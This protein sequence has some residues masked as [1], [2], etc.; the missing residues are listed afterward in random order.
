MA[1]GKKFVM[2]ET[3]SFDF[4]S[5]GKNM[6]GMRISEH[7]RGFRVS[8]SLEKE[9]VEW[10]VEVL[11]DLYCCGGGNTLGKKWPRKMHDLWL[12]MR[13]NRSGRYLVLTEEKGN[14]VKQ[15]FIPDGL[16]R[17]DGDR[18]GRL[19]M[20]Y[21]TRDCEPGSEGEDDDGL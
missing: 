1:E 18:S 9:E 15:I 16:K 5:E 13:W 10:L 17:V 2:I 6:K 20:Y 7:Y 14:E 3:K 21:R 8:I 12:A 19:Y 4:V 11:G